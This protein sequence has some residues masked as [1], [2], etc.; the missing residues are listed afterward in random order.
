M[1]IEI[2]YR[3]GHGLMRVM[4]RMYEKTLSLF[5]QDSFLT[6]APRSRLQGRLCR[7]RKSRLSL[8]MK[9]FNSHIRKN[10]IMESEFKTYYSYYC[11]PRVESKHYFYIYIIDNIHVLSILFTACIPISSRK[12]TTQLLTLHLAVSSTNV[13][14]TLGRQIR[15]C[16]HSSVLCEKGK[17]FL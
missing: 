5:I 15:I 9:I 7:S 8:F 1:N 11:I 17:I 2:V 10:W 12:G 16:G 13:Y 3:N 6:V 4:S 14:P